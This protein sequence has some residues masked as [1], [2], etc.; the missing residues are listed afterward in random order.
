MAV[1]TEI[2]R[3]NTQ[4]IELDLTNNTLDLVI[5]GDGFFLLD[6]GQGGTSYSRLGEFELNQDGIIVTQNGRFLQGFGLDFEGN[7]QP[8][9]II[10]TRTLVGSTLLEMTGLK[11]SA[12]GTVT[13]TYSTGQVINLGQL[14]LAVFENPSLLQPLSVIEWGATTESGPGYLDIPGV[15]T[16]GGL[17]PL[18]PGESRA[19]D[20][21]NTAELDPSSSSLDIAI[22]GAGF[23]QLVDSQG[24]ISYTRQGDFALDHSGN[25]VTPD[26]KFLQGYGLDAS[27]I[28]QPATTLSINDELVDN[29]S[30]VTVG[31]DG[32]LVA[33]YDDGKSTNVGLIFLATFDNEEALQTIGNS[34]W[35]ATPESGQA[36]IETANYGE[37]GSLRSATAQYRGDLLDYQIIG[38]SDGFTIRPNSDPLAIE[39]VVGV[40]RLN[41]ADTNLALDIDGIAGKVYRLYK[42]AFNRSPDKEGLGYWIEAMDDGDTLHDVSLSFINSDEFQLLNGEN[43]SNEVFLTALYNN[44]LGRAPDDEGYQWWLDVLDSGADVREGVLIGFSESTENKA[45]VIDLIGSGIL[46]EEWLG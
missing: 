27:G 35:L 39:T 19:R 12:E 23:F 33:N 26:G 4:S 28:R 2:N 45:N 21:S 16:R 18:A 37:N 14:V 42:A 22:D 13:A 31:H 5:E 17:R 30:A 9:S 43:P 38:N 44:A 24:H 40:D 32:L 46:Y 10:S 25:F 6:D 36:I 34:Q 41:F 20:I 7:R 3:Q 11:I 1:N 29:V 8:I 15:D